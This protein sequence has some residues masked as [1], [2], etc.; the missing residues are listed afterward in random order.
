MSKHCQLTYNAIS[1][2]GD[3]VSHCCMQRPVVIKNNWNDITNLNEFYKNNDQFA[4]IRN[5]LE[6]GI[7]HPACK[8]CWYYEEKY[9]SSPRIHNT[10]F[11]PDDNRKIVDI[12]YVDLRLSSECNLQCKMCNPGSSSQLYK[13]TVELT[14]LNIDHPWYIDVPGNPKYIGELKKV[15][16]TNLLNLILDLPNLKGIRFAGGEP[17]LM[18]EVE[19]LLFKLV[20][21]NK[22]DI[23]IEFITNCTSA[24]TRVLSTL[25]KFKKVMIMCSIDGVEDTI[26]YQRY[27]VKWET[28]ENTFIKFY[29]S[30]CK[31]KLVP[32]IGI[33]NYL[34]LHRFF[35]W[36]NQFTKTQ[37]SYT[38]I[39]GTDFFNF[40]YVPEDVRADFY[41]KFSKIKLK[42]VDAKWR[43][44]QKSV[45]YETLEPTQVHCNELHQYSQKVWDY[46]CKEKFLDRYPYMN[47][48]I[49]RAKK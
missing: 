12:E 37:I 15:D 7:E 31:T 1:I 11:A 47:Y 30:K 44:F 21:K 36:T 16:T 25:E 24:K 9:N 48:M 4:K 3:V 14:K 46:R 2:N 32:C 27:P 17:F 28:V 26:E 6:N 13:L 8:S 35:A 45:M 39:A 40:R 34:D 19:E 22:L 18:P 42:N 23:E 43:K 33:L 49:D 5:D 20:E 41:N 10:Y 38:E 29:N